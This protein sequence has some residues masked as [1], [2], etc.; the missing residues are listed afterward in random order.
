MRPDLSGVDRLELN[1]A[2]RVSFGDLLPRTTQLFGDG[3]A[4]A[5]VQRQEPVDFLLGPSWRFVA[6]FFGCAKVGRVALPV[7]LGHRAVAGQPFSAGRKSATT[8]ADSSAEAWQPHRWSA[9]PATTWASRSNLDRSA[10]LPS[11]LA[12]PGETRDVQRQP[13]EVGMQAGRPPPA[14]SRSPNTGVAVTAA[15]RQSTCAGSRGRARTLPR[16]RTRPRPP[17]RT[18]R[19]RAAPAAG[20]GCPR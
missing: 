16:D 17:G 19:R 2:T 18:P 1:L 7:N 15:V 4:V 9:S 20:A 11:A 8:G 14:A 5:G 12:P 13:E 6:T 3:T 10:W